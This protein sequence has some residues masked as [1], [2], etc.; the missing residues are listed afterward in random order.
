VVIE[1]EDTDHAPVLPRSTRPAT[2]APQERTGGR[3]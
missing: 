1:Q 3:R 2:A